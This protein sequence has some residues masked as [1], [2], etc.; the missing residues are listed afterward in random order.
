LTMENYKQVQ[1]EHSYIA[2]VGKLMEPLTKPLDLGWKEDVSLL[3]GLA[4]KEAIVGTMATLYGVGNVDETS[5]SLIEKIRNSMPFTAAVAMIIIIMFYSPCVAA[6]STFYAEVP[7]WAWR[8]FYTIYPNVFAYF[9][10]L[11]G[12]TLIKL[13]S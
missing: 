4:A 8:A 12:V 3:V 7:Q 11:L 2:R 13:F 9:A 5:K 1:I 10:A 6:M